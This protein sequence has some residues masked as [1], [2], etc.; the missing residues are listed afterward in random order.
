MYC[1]QPPYQLMH[2]FFR[3]FG[4]GLCVMPPLGS[5][6]IPRF[7]PGTIP[8][9]KFKLAAQITPQSWQRALPDQRA[10]PPVRHSSTAAERT[11]R[12]ITRCTQ[13][14]RQPLTCRHRAEALR[15]AMFSCPG[16]GWSCAHQHGFRTSSAAHAA[17]KKSARDLVKRITKGA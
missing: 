11:L 13:A 5:S 15:R 10:H 4:R 8:S 17:V 14:A 12:T 6:C 2:T 1:G 7:R 9:R 16:D 3:N